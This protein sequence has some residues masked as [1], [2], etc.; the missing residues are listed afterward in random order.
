MTIKSLT[1]DNLITLLK[2]WEHHYDKGSPTNW[3]QIIGPILRPAGCAAFHYSVSNEVR[4][5]Q[6]LVSSWG[7]RGGQLNQTKFLIQ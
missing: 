1:V 4:T 5:Q 7:S 2:E 6:Q 3:C